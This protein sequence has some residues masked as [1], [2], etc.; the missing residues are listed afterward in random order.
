MPKSQAQ[1]FGAFFSTLDQKLDDYDIRS[2]GV[3]MSNLEDVFLKINQEFAPD[4][5]G[6]LKG[7]GFDDSKNSSHNSVEIENNYAKSIGHS[8]GYDKSR[9]NEDSQNSE[10]ASQ[11]DSMNNSKDFE[12]D[13]TNGQNLIRGS[14]CVRSCTASA[15]KRMIIYKRDWCGLI[16]QIIIPLILVIFGLWLASGPSK[17]TQSPPRHLSTGWYEGP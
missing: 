16:C 17:V 1:N 15:A 9:G 12:I 10:T 3:S 6:D 13:E 11:E 8:T 5:F 7:R 4:L 14:S 2:Y